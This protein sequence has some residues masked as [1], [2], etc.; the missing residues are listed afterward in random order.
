MIA[1]TPHALAASGFCDHE[2]V[3]KISNMHMSIAK[4]INGLRYETGGLKKRSR[5]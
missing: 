5:A 4:Q 2:W 1:V 3:T